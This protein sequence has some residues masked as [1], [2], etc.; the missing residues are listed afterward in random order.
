[1]RLVKYPTD[2]AMKYNHDRIVVM[3]LKQYR[4]VGF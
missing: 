2:K 3:K 1:M 4:E